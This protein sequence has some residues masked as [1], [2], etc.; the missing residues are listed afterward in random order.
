[1]FCPRC[2]KEVKNNQKFCI[3]CGYDLSEDLKEYKSD[4]YSKSYYKQPKQKFDFS[5]LIILGG[6]LFKL[7]L[8]IVALMVALSGLKIMSSYMSFD[9]FTND[10]AKYNSYMETP[11]QIPELLPPQSLQD[12][13]NNL[14]DVQTFLNLYLRYSNDTM[15]EKQKVFD[16]YRKQ[17]LKIEMIS[18][19]NLLK[20]D[21]GNSMPQTKRE[22]KKCAKYYNKILAPVGMYLVSD[23]AYSKYH[24]KEDYQFT[25]K[26][27]GKYLSSDMKSY[28]YLR[29]KHNG[30]IIENGGY[31]S[32]TPKEM[33]KRIADYEKYM[34]DNSKFDK[35]A[36]VQDMLYYYAFAY[37][38]AEDRQEMQ[39]IRSKKFQK[40][41]KRFVRQHKTSKLVPIFSKMVTSANGISPSQF[42]ELYPYE[43]EKTFDSVRPENSELEDVFADIRKDIIKEQGDRGYKWVFSQVD[44]TWAP[45]NTD[46]KLS[47]DTLLFAENGQGFDIYDN[48]FKKT[49]QSLL[50]D[51]K[52][53][54][55]LKDDQLLVYNPQC[56]QIARVEYSYGNFSTKILPS[57]AIRKYFPE[58]LI[59]NLDNIGNSP[60]QVIKTTVKQAYMFISPTGSDF[61]GYYL[62]SDI[63]VQTGEL[64][65]I[66]VVDTTNTVNLEWLPESTDGKQYFI[67]FLTNLEEPSSETSQETSN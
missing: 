64:S 51:S 44:G 56:L 30:E 43:Y 31:L 53:Q 49:N 26:K 12:M 45:F 38:F 65:N 59:I 19:D 57:K 61:E 35:I 14:K 58:T 22:F 24:L 63:P 2:G 25:Y 36:E 52:A 8:L 33:N 66:F 42:E 47:R 48:R 1:M 18:N 60:V 67:T 54:V 28:L 29:A 9:S 23:T 41:D 27:F 37:I 32:V 11:A 50:I 21:I 34:L 62:H 39:A 16:T 40:W 3:N 15:E 20:E 13:V 4:I 7:F 46:V 55:I 10:K 5:K 17:I 6:F